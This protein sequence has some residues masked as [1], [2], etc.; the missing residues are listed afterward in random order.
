MK[1]NISYFFFFVFLIL[2]VGILVAV[3][4]LSQSQTAQSR[5]DLATAAKNCNISQQEVNL[6]SEEK[7]F[8]SLLNKYRKQNK[9]KTVKQDDTL[10]KAAAW[11]SSDMAANDSFDHIDSLRRTAPE[12]LSD[13]GHA[14]DAGAKENIANAY[15][16][17]D[18]VMKAWQKSKEHDRA[19]KT[20]NIKYIGVARHYDRNS[21]FGWYWTL[22]MGTKG[23]GGKK[24]SGDDNS[25]EVTPTP[26]N[27]GKDG[28][29]KEGKGK[30]DGTT[31]EPTATA[32]VTPTPTPSGT[33]LKLSVKI[34]GIG[35]SGNRRPFDQERD[36]EVFVSDRNDTQVADAI[37]TLT[38]DGS[39][40]YVGEIDSGVTLPGGAYIIRV[41]MDNTLRKV[42]SGQFVQIKEATVN[43]LPQIT[44]YQGD[45]DQNNRVDIRDYNIFAKCLE[46][47]DEGAVV[48]LNSDGKI[49]ILDF[50]LLNEVFTTQ[51][52]A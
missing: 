21:Q 19:M 5:A 37:G 44:L 35:G 10:T 36:I 45:F 7:K 40:F 43:A 9:R 52:G 23:K 17:A 42:V 27:Q 50:N 15:E 46:E 30:K 47:C 6:D 13:C 28:D 12:R 4:Q 3:S 20:D 26:K 49:D 32:T 51:Q 33:R 8:I 48:D 11:M 39:N 25:D 34:P 1:K 31:K 41:R 2:F 22:D 38:F 24:D 14:Q 18:E 29:K 16:T